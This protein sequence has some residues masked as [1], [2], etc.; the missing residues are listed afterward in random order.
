M[1]YPLKD[2]S[3]SDST[4]L[5]AHFP[6]VSLPILFLAP[7]NINHKGASGQK[8]LPQPRKMDFSSLPEDRSKEFFAMH[9]GRIQDEP[10]TLARPQGR[11]N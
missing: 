4:P 11:K 1:F 3:H 9:P 7:Q 10:G 6:N 8:R 5:S 2:G